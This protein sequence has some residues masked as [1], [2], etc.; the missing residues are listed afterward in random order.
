MSRPAPWL[1]LQGGGTTPGSL[2][3]GLSQSALAVAPAASSYQT[4]ITATCVQPSPC[5]GKTKTVVVSLGVTAPPAAI[6]TTDA[7]L[8][9]N[10]TAGAGVPLSQWTGVQNSGGGTLTIQSIT[11][12]DSWIAIAG[13]PAAVPA[14]PPVPVLITVNPAGL[15]AGFYTSSISISTSAGSISLP[16]NLSIA[17]NPTINLAPAGAQ[18][19]TTVGSPLGNSAG[20]FL[21]SVQGGSTIKWQAS[22]LPGA[23]WLHL[24]NSPGTASSFLPGT[25]QFTVYPTSIV[26]STAQAYYGI[27]RVISSDVVNS[28]V[29]FEVVLNLQPAATPVKPD[30]S[31]AG[32]VFVSGES[33][34]QIPAQTVQVYASS[35]APLEYQAST[36]TSDGAA[37]L[38]VSPSTGFASS[39]APA[40]SSVFDSCCRTR[41]GCLSRR[42][43]LCLFERSG[44]DGQRDAPGGIARRHDH[45]VVRSRY[46]CHR[47]NFVHARAVDSH[48]SGPDA[49]LSAAARLAGGT[50]RRNHHRLRHTLDRCAG[51]CVIFERRSSPDV[52]SRRHNFRNLLRDVDTACRVAAGNDFNRGD[53]V[54]LSFGYGDDHGRSHGKLGSF[55]R[56]GRNLEHFPK[57]D[58]KPTRAR[59]CHPD[60]RIEPGDNHDVGRIRAAPNHARRYVRFDRWNRRAAVLCKSRPHQ[61]SSTIRALAGDAI[62]RTS[63]RQRNAE[64]HL[65]GY[66][67][68]G[69]AGDR[70]APLRSGNRPTYELYPGL[71]YSSRQAGRIRRLVSGGSWHDR[72]SG[73]K[74]CCVSG[75]PTSKMSRS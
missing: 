41:S 75:G 13:V 6:S 74:W 4:T 57:H 40:Q 1:N 11:A 46:I 55:D 65:A 33:Q 28:P 51:G 34:S 26:N 47:P 73:G 10:T 38:S 52:E 3:I 21:V 25:I 22:V 60:L 19:Q 39:I 9:F 54:Q 18:F 71:G 48:A 30:P 53:R 5:A 66:V 31:P 64:R 62:R 24:S 43:Q 27:I 7:L 20:S 15:A 8:S 42:C 37:W 67:G 49:Q 2:A 68:I 61:R 44:K 50:R 72:C 58:R 56:A 29:D 63:K 14:G 36:T 35:T 32:L 17:P 12:A 70:G 59:F 45:R 69:C 23:D 16:V